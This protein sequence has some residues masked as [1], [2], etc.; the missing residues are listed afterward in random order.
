MTSRWLHL[1][2]DLSFRE[3]WLDTDVCL[4]MLF[5]MRMRMYNSV[6]YADVFNKMFDKIY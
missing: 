6:L 5:L 3:G 2:I 1:V 4:K